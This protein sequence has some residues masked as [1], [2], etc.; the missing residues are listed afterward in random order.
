MEQLLTLEVVKDFWKSNF[1]IHQQHAD[2]SRCTEEYKV[3][4]LLI[5]Q[6]PTLASVKKKDLMRTLIRLTAEANLNVRRFKSSTKVNH[7][8]VIRK[9]REKPR[10][11]ATEV[12][13]SLLNIRGMVLEDQNKSK[14]VKDNVVIPGNSANHI[15]MITESFLTPGHKDEEILFSF[16]DYTIKRCD[17]DTKIGRKTKQGGCF[18]LTSPDIS[19]CE[20]DSKSN[21]VCEMIITEHPTLDLSIVTVYRPPDTTLAEF[22]EILQMVDKHLTTTK[23][24]NSV[25][26][27]DFNFPPEVVSWVTTPEDG[28][29]PVP[30]TCVSREDK[31]QLQSLLELV[32]KHLLQQIVNVPTRI[33]NTLDLLFT[34][35]PDKFH[36]MTST[37]MSP[38]SDHNLITFNSDFTLDTEEDFKQ[39]SPPKAS[40]SMG[41]F[42]FSRA[43]S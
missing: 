11:T 7:Y 43:N 10:S 5:D 8:N 20:I 28:I 40:N 24:T 41:D 21:G 16:P 9:Q 15:I 25:I 1:Y 32:D 3:R 29:V 30:T 26:A 38:A 2:I 39:Q 17:R 19:T 12:K 27:G 22:T 13:F 18:I 33:D 35:C 34:S 37:V 23:F 42:N 6:H 31:I 14:F 36:T 4:N